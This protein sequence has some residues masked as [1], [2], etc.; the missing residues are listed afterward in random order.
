MQIRP[1]FAAHRQPFLLLTGST[2]TLPWQLTG[3]LNQ[4][5]CPRSLGCLWMSSLLR[6]AA[7]GFLQRNCARLALSPPWGLCC[8]LQRPLNRRSMSSV[9]YSQQASNLTAGSRLR[10][11]AVAPAAAAP[12]LATA[13]GGCRQ[14]RQC[15]AAGAA[16]FGSPAAEQAWRSAGPSARLHTLRLALPAR[17]QGPRLPAPL[18]AVTP[19]WQQ[20]ESD[21]GREQQPQPW[22]QFWAR[23]SSSSAAA[24][25]AASS[26]DAV[27]SGGRTAAQPLAGGA[28]ASSARSSTSEERELKAVNTAVWVNAIIFVAKMATWA[29]TGSG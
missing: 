16:S 7:S 22:W 11:A 25:A 18:R 29:V 21:D 10:W 28:G 26:S 12:P 9:P 5:R 8:D 20:P 24:A 1:E 14:A 15:I 13:A 4:T 23:P 17:E 2:C 3:W 6:Q 19:A 27:R